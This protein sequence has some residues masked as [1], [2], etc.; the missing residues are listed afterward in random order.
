MNP[1]AIP[2]WADLQMEFYKKGRIQNVFKLKTI[3]I[4]DRHYGQLEHIRFS[5]NEQCVA[6]MGK[7]FMVSFWDVKSWEKKTD[8]RA[9][10]DSHAKFYLKELNLDEI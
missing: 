4:Q 6:I 7:D 8:F 10:H 3:E 5:K 1:T 9:Y 2:V